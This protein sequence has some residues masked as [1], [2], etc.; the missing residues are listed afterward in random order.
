VLSTGRGRFSP[1]YSITVSLAEEVK[2]KD[3]PDSQN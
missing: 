1:T 2:H 3:Q